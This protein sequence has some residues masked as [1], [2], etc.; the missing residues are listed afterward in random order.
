[1]K[2]RLQPGEATPKTRP[3]PGIPDRPETAADHKHTARVHLN[4]VRHFR[5]R[6][7]G[8]GWDL[9]WPTVLLGWAGDARRRAVAVPAQRDMFGA[10]A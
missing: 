4:Q 10:P 6:A 7:H 3:Q 1:M 9:G 2:T 8:L 5:E